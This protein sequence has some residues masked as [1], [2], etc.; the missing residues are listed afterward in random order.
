MERSCSESYEPLKEAIE[1]AKENIEKIN[2]DEETDEIC[3]N[4]GE[5]HGNKVW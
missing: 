5:Q 4:C 3:E 1:I 2:M